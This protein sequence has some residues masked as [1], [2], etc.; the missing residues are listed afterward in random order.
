MEPP[1]RCQRGRRDRR[2]WT[3]R[4]RR[5]PARQRQQPLSRL[6]APRPAGLLDN[7]LAIAAT[8]NGGL[9][10]YFTGTEQTS[11]RLANHH[12]D[13]KAVGGYVLAPPSRVGGKQYRLL[14]ANDA[15]D[16]VLDWA[17]VIDVLEPQR[18]QLVIGMSSATADPSRLIAWVER[19]QEGNR[20]S[21]LFWAACRAI[22]S[23]QEHILAD[24]EAAAAATGLPD[25][26]IRRTIASARR[27]A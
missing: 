8:P 27:S 6:P 7:A 19:L 17:D 1:S 5:R 9:H 14:I 12:I 25:C 4:P 13:F 20:N 22:E 24:M 3:R 26:E 2:A 21:G 16:A 15:A 18:E 10:L 11:G 23:G